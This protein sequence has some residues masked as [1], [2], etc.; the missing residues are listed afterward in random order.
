MK[1]IGKDVRGPREFKYTN[2]R[3]R[4]VPAARSFAVRYVPFGL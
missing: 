2:N 3:S 1:R 4:F